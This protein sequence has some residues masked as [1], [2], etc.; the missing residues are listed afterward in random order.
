MDELSPFLTWF[1]PEEGMNA[2][3]MQLE[4]ERLFRR[5]QAITALLDD[6]IDEEVVYDLL[7]DDGINPHD[8]V[9]NAIDNFEAMLRS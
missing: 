3:D 4:I 9:T 7:A 6:R 8:W 1:T 2:A 5:Q